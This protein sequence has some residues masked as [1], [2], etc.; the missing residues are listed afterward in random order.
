MRSYAAPLHKIKTDDMLPLKLLTP[1]QGEN[2][3]H[4]KDTY[5]YVT[6]QARGCRPPCRRKWNAFPCKLGGAQA[7]GA[8]VGHGV[9]PARVQAGLDPLHASSSSALPCPLQ[10]DIRMP[11]R[12]LRQLEDGYAL[13]RFRAAIEAA[14]QA[15]AGL[16]AGRQAG[17]EA[18]QQGGVRVLRGASK[19]MPGHA[20]RAQA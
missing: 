3:H 11:G 14:V 5:N 20:L 18:L 1:F 17:G 9:T 12:H 6:V 16:V 19:D 2:D 10:T 8:G 13:P 7:G 4:I 15:R